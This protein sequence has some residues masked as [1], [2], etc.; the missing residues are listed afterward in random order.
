[1]GTGELAK[2]AQYLFLQESGD[3]QR[4]NEVSGLFSW[5]KSVLWASFSALTRYLAHSRPVQKSLFW[6]N[7]QIQIH[8]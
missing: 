4:K 8:L 2:M 5:L 7:Y 3:E 6:N 1:M